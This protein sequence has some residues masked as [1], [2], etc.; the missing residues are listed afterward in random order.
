[1]PGVFT[2]F[3]LGTGHKQSETNQTIV[4]LYKNCMGEKAINDGP[5]GVFGSIFGSGMDAKVRDTVKL[6][7]AKTPVRV[8]MV[9]HSRGAVLCHLLANDLV[10]NPAT[11]SVRINIMAFDPV[12]MSGG[13]GDRSS[14]LPAGSIDSYVA[15]IQEHESKGI[16]PVTMVSGNDPLFE[17][18]IFVPMPGT[19][20]GLQ[21][22]TTTPGQIGVQMAARYLAHHGSGTGHLVMPLKQVCNLFGKL[23]LESP[24]KYNKKGLVKKREVLGKWLGVDKR[25]QTIDK[26]MQLMGNK[27]EGMDFRNT[28]YFFNL[29][30]A[31][32]FRE[33]FPAL[34]RRF[35]GVFSQ[36]QQVNAELND[37]EHNYRDIWQSF[38]KCGML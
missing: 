23:Y 14:T 27:D 10:N 25:T 3:N 30:H 35:E 20:G 26:A 16:Y 7:A 12:H 37:I 21:I 8:N 38:D 5:L 17:K 28:P 15:V 19:H 2:V 13:H 32:A 24:V 36:Q 11:Q 4:H 18:S 31:Y 9:G 22:N 6:I 29:Y 1:M 34:Y 33:S